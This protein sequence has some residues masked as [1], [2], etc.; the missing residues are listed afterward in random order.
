MTVRDAS[1]QEF[2]DELLTRAAD[3]Q[4]LIVVYNDMTCASYVAEGRNTLDD[5]PL[6]SQMI[7]LATQD[8]MRSLKIPG[9]ISITTEVMP[10]NGPDE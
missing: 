5:G 3:F 1:M 6:L 9:I 7:T 2:I 4:C 8:V 10:L